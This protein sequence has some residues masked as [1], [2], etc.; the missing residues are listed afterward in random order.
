M[1]YIERELKEIF[2]NVTYY[3]QYAM[4]MNRITRHIGSK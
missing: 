4:A 1:F 2:R 3:E